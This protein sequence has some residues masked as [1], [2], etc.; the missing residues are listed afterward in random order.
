MTKMLMA[1]MA[2]A[3]SVPAY[4]AE[5]C[6]RLDNISGWTTPNDKTLIVENYQHQKFKLTFM[7]SCPN[8]KYHEKLGFKVF[9][10]TRLSCLTR[11]DSVIQRDVIG[12]A[13]CPIS[14]VE[15]YTPEM[16]KDDKASLEAT[17][18]HKD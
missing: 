15:L 6:L 9:G 12:P 7:G 5:P 10:G 18:Q 16:E 17:R 2:L 3:I 1:A 13:R 4:A 14:K 11:G 8:L